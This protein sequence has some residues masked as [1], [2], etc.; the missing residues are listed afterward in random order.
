MPKT[1]EKKS[2][3]KTKTV[4]KTVAKKE[5]SKPAVKAVVAKTAVKKE[6]KTL[7]KESSVPVASVKKVEHKGVTVDVFG[8][9]G[10]KSATMTL[11]G[12][13]FNAKINPNLMAQAVRVYLANQRSG[14]ASSK[15]RGEV[16]GTTKKIYRQKGTGRARH[17]AAK[18][19][20]FVG[21]GVTF[22]PKPHSFALTLP[23][24]MKRNAL[25]SALSSKFQ[26]KKIMIVDFNGATGKTK[27]IAGVLKT[28]GLIQKNGDAHSVLLVANKD[29]EMV[30]RSARN[31]EGLSV[32]VAGNL[33]AYEVLNGNML[34]FV[35][36][37]VDT[38][39]NTFLKGN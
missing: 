27:E 20:L 18:A 22:G 26:E 32:Q 23:K 36:E 16:N 30:N 11:P 25:F 24:K 9:D 14:T 39:K 19:P 37:T 8:M 28:L 15:T 31:I 2:I 35:K 6:A 4:K 5:V 7:V 1:E 33:N 38:L 13:I 3:Q 17:G 10:S 34:V 29:Q 21:G 12:E